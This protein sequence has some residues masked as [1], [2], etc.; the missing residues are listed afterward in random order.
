MRTRSVLAV[1][2]LAA[3]GLAAP[4]ASG[5][6]TLPPGVPVPPVDASALTPARVELG[7]RLFFDPRLS[8][9]G[10]SACGACHRQE[11]AFTDGR[12]RAVGATGEPHTRGSMSLVN[13][14][15][16]RALTRAE[17]PIA[18]LEEQALV[19][20]FSEHPVELGLKGHEARIF[21]ALEADPIYGRLFREA[22][23]S[24]EPR[25]ATETIAAAIAA[26]ERT[27]V[28]FRSPYDRFRYEGVESA[29]TP[30]AQRGFALFEGRA[31]C[32]RCHD[33]IN[34]DGSPNG[35]RA[36]TLRNIGV[37]YPYLQDGSAP[38]LDAVLDRHGNGPALAPWERA[39]LLAFLDS[40]TDLDALVDTRWRD[41]WRT[42][43]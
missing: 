30:A 1:V 24:H 10:N 18:S 23:P 33:G 32:A 40:L 42:Q 17:P 35:S 16:R 34:F 7:R 28:S 4:G 12:A 6:W 43:W 26:F 13:V 27:I 38:T 15:Y 20:M 22:F 37:T 29:L 5:V 8:V 31:G 41:P 9:N 36:P 19:P 39:E 14:A 11:F 2:G 25:I 3:L 21:A